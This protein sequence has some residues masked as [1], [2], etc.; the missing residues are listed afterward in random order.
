M[1]CSPLGSSVHG[2][3]QTRIL[4]WVAIPFSRAFSLPRDRTWVSHIA[5]RFFFTIWPTRKAPQIKLYFVANTRYQRLT[6]SAVGIWAL[7]QL[8]NST[9]LV[10]NTRNLDNSWFLNLSSGSMGCLC[11][12]QKKALPLDGSKISS[13][14]SHTSK[15][16][17]WR[18]MLSWGKKNPKNKKQNCPPVVGC[19]SAPRCMTWQVKCKQA[20]FAAHSVCREQ[21]AQPHTHSLFGPHPGGCAS[22]QPSSER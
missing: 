10:C 12:N 22:Q 6:F 9:E 3:S 4:E 8:Q 18:A 11:V 16:K 13:G 2:I 7:T 19:S 21:P 17:V 1:D 5:G 15:C 14:Q 20:A